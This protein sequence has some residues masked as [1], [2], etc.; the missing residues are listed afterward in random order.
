MNLIE[1]ASQSALLE[2]QII[3]SQGQISEAMELILGE[4]QTKLI[5]KVDAYEIM[6]QRLES[7]SEDYRAYAKQF[8]GV[9]RSLDQAVGAMKARIRLAMNVMDTKEVS[10]N[11]FV[12]KLSAK[13]GSL[14]IHNE[15]LIPDRFKLI[16]TIIEIDKPKI[17]AAIEAGEI[18]TGA[19]II[20]TLRSQ[21][22]AK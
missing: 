8:T 12:F 5:E 21:A 15:D 11:A 22:R 3:E 9:A 10:G 13:T 14:N 19:E 17:K 1:I 4:V 6:M 7:R 2:Q 18:V 20:P 16:K